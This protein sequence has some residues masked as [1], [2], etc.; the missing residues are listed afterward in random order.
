[1]CLRALP[2]LSLAFYRALQI[3]VSLGKCVW[4]HSIKE[5][6]P[7]HRYF[8]SLHTRVLLIVL[9]E[10]YWAGLP[11]AYQCQRLM[12]FLPMTVAKLFQIWAASA[13]AQ[14]SQQHLPAQLTTGVYLQICNYLSLSAFHICLLRSSSRSVC[15]RIAFECHVDVISPPWSWAS[16]TPVS[17][18]NVDMCESFFESGMTGL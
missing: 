8:L 6:Y 1:V 7:C 11:L 12:L 3:D 2:T 14:H 18:A 5:P 15:L 13:A 10:V 17:H 4:I 16:M 9:L